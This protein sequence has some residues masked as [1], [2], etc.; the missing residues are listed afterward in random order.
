MTRT[1]L[2]V[3][4]RITGHL[5]FLFMD[6]AGRQPSICIR[7][8][9]GKLNQA[10]AKVKGIM[11]MMADDYKSKGVSDTHVQCQKISEGSY[12]CAIDLLNADGDKVGHE[13]Y[14]VKSKNGKWL[15]Q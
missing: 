8:L 9:E 14:N 4:C 6:Y 15:I 1:S 10:K 11:P 13:D 5:Q 2:S 3:G 12:E 7:H